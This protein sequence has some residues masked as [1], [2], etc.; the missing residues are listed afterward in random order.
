MHN[1]VAFNIQK[2]AAFLRD[3]PLA[4]PLVPPGDPAAN[5]NPNQHANVIGAILADPVWIAIASILIVMVIV[6]FIGLVLMTRSKRVRSAQ[7][8]RYAFLCQFMVIYALCV[9]IILEGSAMLIILGVF[10]M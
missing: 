5:D 2:L 6:L 8:K 7:L 4:T 10:G 3:G 1:N 9:Y